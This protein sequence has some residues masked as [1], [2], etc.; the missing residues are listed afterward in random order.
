[1][2]A[3]AYTNVDD[4]LRDVVDTST[5]GGVWD[6]VL[7]GA[8][9]SDQYEIERVRIPE[10]LAS[11]TAP[12]AYSMLNYEN[13]DSILVGVS[14]VGGPGGTILQ[15]TARQEYPL[16]IPMHRA[17]YAEDEVDLEGN[18]FLENHYTLY[19]DDMDW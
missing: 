10:F 6:W 16:R 7:G 17:F 5:P 3:P 15:G 9:T 4:V 14:T 12:T 19:L 13:W 2:T 8:P 11:P 18:A 1:M